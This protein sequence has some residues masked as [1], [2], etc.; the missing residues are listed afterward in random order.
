[1]SS[2]TMSSARVI[3]AMVLATD[4]STAEREHVCTRCGVVTY[5]RTA[6]WRNG[7]GSTVRCV[8]L[9]ADWIVSWSP[10]L[11]SS[12]VCWRACRGDERSD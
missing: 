9:D 10:P 6:S 7:H 2:I 1:M 3:R 11:G 8:V 5:L 4:P 12:P